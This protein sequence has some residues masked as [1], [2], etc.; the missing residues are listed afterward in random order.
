MRY[1]FYFLLSLII[2]LI[3]SSCQDG[4]APIGNINPNSF[5]QGTIRY[6]G[7]KSKFPDS[8]KVFGIYAAAFKKFPSDSSGLVNEF[9]MGNLYLTLESLPYP[10]DSSEFTLEIIDAPV[11]I[12]YIVIAMQT[13]SSIESQMAIGVYTESGD[14]TNPSQLYIDKSKTY[15]INIKVDFDSLPPQPF[16]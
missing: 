2:I 15:H 12:E 5:I 7:G 8:S 13:D 1:I 16:K 14:N 3:A 6:V 4:L 10:S 11:N 9:L